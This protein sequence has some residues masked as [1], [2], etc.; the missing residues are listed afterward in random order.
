MNGRGP[1]DPSGASFVPGIPSAYTQPLY[2][3]FLIPLYWIDRSWEVVG[4]AQVA[5][6]GAT[7]YLVLR[8]GR[9]FLNERA[10]VLAALLATLNPYL[11]WH[12]VHINRELLDQLLASA[13]FLL[14]LL[15]ARAGALWLVAATVL[16]FCWG[17]DET[18][19][20]ERGP[21]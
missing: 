2:G 14:V 18:S 21:S 15:A 12:D 7:A 11:V 9:K 20:P 19:A 17:K 10:A 1:R 16:I 8:I 3:W 6:A 5:I 4:S 13:L